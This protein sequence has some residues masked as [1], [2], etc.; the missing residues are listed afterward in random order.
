MQYFADRAVTGASMSTATHSLRERL[1]PAPLVNAA[2]QIVEPGDAAPFPKTHRVPTMLS[3]RE[4]SYLHWLGSTVPAG[5]QVVELG[6]FLGGS[7]AALVEGMRSSGGTH[8]PVLVYDAFLAPDSEACVNSW[9]MK[10]FGLRAGENFR[11]KYEALHAARLD[12]LVIREGWIPEDA[13]LSA[14]QRLYPEQRPID[15][16]FVDAAKSW[17]VHRTI[18]SSFARHLKPGGTL[19]QQDFLDIQTPWLPI[20]MWQL[21]DVFRPLDH[22]RASPTMSFECVADPSLRVDQAWDLERFRDRDLREDTWNRVIS[23]WTDLIGPAAGFLHGHAAKHAALVSD[24]AGVLASARRYEAWLNSRDSQSVYA[25]PTWSEIL[26]AFAEGAPAASVR[27]LRELAAESDVRRS[28][29]RYA[30][31]SS[32]SFL[33]YDVRSSYWH[34]LVDRLKRS[35]CSRIALY[36]AGAHTD[37]LLTTWWPRHGHGITVECVL[38]D[39]STRQ[40]VHG[41]AVRKPLASAVTPGTSIVPSSDAHEPAIVARAKEIFTA[42][43]S[44]VPV[45][46]SERP[47][48]AASVSCAEPQ[49]IRVEAQHLE[50]DAEHRTD[51]GL[52][53]RRA[54]IEAFSQRLGVPAWAKGYVN[55]RDA[56]FLWDLVEAVRPDTIAEIGTASGVSTGLL[57]AA[58][59][60]FGGTAKPRGTVHS[61]DIAERCYFDQS[62][63]VGAAA[64]EALPHL[65]EAIRLNPCRTAIDAARSFGVGEVDLAFIDGDHRHPTPTLDLLAL[66]HALRPGAWVVLHDIELTEV[67]K[68]SRAR[69]VLD[70]DVVTGA[71]TL[72]HRWPFQKTQPC[73]PEAWAN[74][75]GAI[76]LPMN[77][78]DAVGFLLEHLREAWEIGDDSSVLDTVRRAIP[79][80]A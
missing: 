16:L 19:V 18:L 52:P 57:A 10:P 45:Y 78:S 11:A 34:G 7:T 1:T 70:W 72:F 17:G 48:A 4:L 14:Q 77:P 33:S 2:G 69:G 61:F 23:Y 27:A 5:G 20:H 73:F 42:T 54:W 40:D 24:F 25:T 50:A 66:L 60:Y 39:Q 28:L 80:A 53:T 43:H 56:Q 62:R 12:R 76:K 63:M 21:R 6:S 51:L 32:A 74:N 75:I 64:L 36:G 47:S 29:P 15:V 41:I 30:A 59:D 38:D 22:V 8:K 65:R 3:E 37:W 55:Y 68:V 67:A 26:H 71:E 31:Q 35:G 9:W 79:L 13:N 46:T 58:A 49:L 44:I